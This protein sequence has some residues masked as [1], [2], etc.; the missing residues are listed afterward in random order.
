M[1]F[2][3]PG[4]GAA[5]PPAI[6]TPKA[7]SMYTGMSGMFADAGL[8]R[9]SFWHYAKMAMSKLLKAAMRMY[10]PDYHPMNPTECRNFWHSVFHHEDI[11][12][13]LADCVGVGVRF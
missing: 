10:F 4:Y 2:V 3:G 11:R 1:A 7:A 12:D 8:S 5:D 13:P 9:V 6:Y